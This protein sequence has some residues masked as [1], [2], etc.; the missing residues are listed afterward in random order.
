MPHKLPGNESGNSFKSVYQA[1]VVMV[2]LGDWWNTLI[3]FGIVLKRI[4]LLVTVSLI[5]HK[6]SVVVSLVQ[7]S[8][9]CL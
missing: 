6:A 7:F 1:G 5:N 8:L 3:S 2:A 4:N 9:T